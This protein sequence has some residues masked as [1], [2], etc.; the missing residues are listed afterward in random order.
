MKNVTVKWQFFDIQ[1]AIFRRVMLCVWFHQDATLASEIV[2]LFSSRGKAPTTRVWWR[3]TP[4][5]ESVTTTCETEAQVSPSHTHWFTLSPSHTGTRAITHVDC[6]TRHGLS[7]RRDYVDTRSP[8]LTDSS[9]LN[10]DSVWADK[11][12]LHYPLTIIMNSIYITQV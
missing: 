7:S 8:D 9:V 6:L 10:L 2:V 1:M 11:R 5:R 12:K 4:S 3:T